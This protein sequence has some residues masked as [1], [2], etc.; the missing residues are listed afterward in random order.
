MSIHNNGYQSDKTTSQ[1]WDLNTGSDMGSRDT[2]H[3]IW[4]MMSNSSSLLVQ[5]DSLVEKNK[6]TVEV[7]INITN[8]INVFVREY[9]SIAAI[10]D[11]S[12]HTNLNLLHP[13]FVL[14][15]NLGMKQYGM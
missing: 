5:I 8:K 15:L 6:K 12:I 1:I 11:I 10:D 3:M 7:D 4:N 9:D 14:I 13:I 2:D